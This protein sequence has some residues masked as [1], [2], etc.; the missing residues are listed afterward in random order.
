MKAS[1]MTPSEKL[2]RNLM[3]GDEIAKTIFL[4]WI[5]L[6]DQTKLAPVLFILRILTFRQIQEAGKEMKPEGNE[7]VGKMAWEG[8]DILTSLDKPNALLIAG[9]FALLTLN[10]PASLSGAA[11]KIFPE[12]QA[13]LILLGTAL[14]LRSAYR[15]W[16]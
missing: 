6:Q 16:N 2:A 8:L 4:E 9:L 7:H 10:Q 3:A 11:R 5:K 12:T 13:A 1:E 14:D 15:N